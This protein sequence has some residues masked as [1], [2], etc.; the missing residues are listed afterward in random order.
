MTQD[1][2]HKGFCWTFPLYRPSRSLEHFRTQGLGGACHYLTK[3]FQIEAPVAP[4]RSVSSRRLRGAS[5]APPRTLRGGLRTLRGGCTYR[6]LHEDALEGSRGLGYTILRATILIYNIGTLSIRKSSRNSAASNDK[7]IYELTRNT[8]PRGVQFILS[9]SKRFRKNGGPHLK[10][11]R[12]PR[13]KVARPLL[14]R[15]P[16]VVF[17]GAQAEKNR[18]F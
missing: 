3:R 9:D 13:K 12:R 1:A 8:R 6:R 15:P 7:N 17:F 5:K 16:K 10:D 2:A 18:L 11:S 4:S 14:L